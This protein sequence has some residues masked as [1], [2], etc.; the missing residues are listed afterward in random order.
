M[1]K[2]LALLL[3]LFR[4]T[5]KEKEQWENELAAQFALAKSTKSRTPKATALKHGTPKATALK[6]AFRKL[7]NTYQPSLKLYLKAEEDRKKVVHRTPSLS[8]Q[9]TGAH[10][11]DHFQWGQW[12]KYES[13]CPVCL[14]PSTMR[15]QSQEEIDTADARQCAENMENNVIGTK[16]VATKTGCYCYDQNCHGD[17]NGIGCW[18]CTKL[19]FSGVA[20]SMLDETVLGFLCRIGRDVCHC[21]CQVTF[22]ESRRY[23]ISNAIMSEVQT[24]SRETQELLDKGGCTLFFNYIKNTL[25]NNIVCKQQSADSCSRV[26]VLMDTATKTAIE[27]LHDDD[28]HA[29]PHVKCGLQGII[30]G[31]R[32]MVSIHTNGKKV[33]M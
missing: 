27:V 6:R 10:T 18:K 25:N 7:W 3:V 20:P 15:L 26:D 33:S 17:E 5:E 32:N 1:A 21:V 23:T 19:A 31:C 24:A 12:P 30:P 9:A 14:H 16:G 11:Q 8:Y 2:T 13:G 22:D 28:I 4:Q 29:N